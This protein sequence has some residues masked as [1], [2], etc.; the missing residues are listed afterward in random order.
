MI[1]KFERSNRTIKVKGLTYVFIEHSQLM[2]FLKLILV[3]SNQ[4]AFFSVVFVKNN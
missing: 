4:F 1:D 3:K 2:I